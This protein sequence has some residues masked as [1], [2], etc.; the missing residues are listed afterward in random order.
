MAVNSRN[1][2]RVPTYYLKRVHSWR[3]SSTFNDGQ[4]ASATL[5]VNMLTYVNML[6]ITGQH[7]GQHVSRFVL[8]YMLNIHTAVHQK[9][10]AAAGVGGTYSATFRVTTS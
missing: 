2:A 9:R 10:L 3:N 4:A 6:T 5:V 1:G 8:V 7:I